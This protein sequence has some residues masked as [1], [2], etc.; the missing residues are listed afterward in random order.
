MIEPF[1]ESI[2][3]YAHNQRRLAL[4]RK[5]VRSRLTD[6]EQSELDSL[7][8]MLDKKLASNDNQLLDTLDKMKQAIANL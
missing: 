1:D 2:S 5:S 7:Q 8:A 6:D 3:W 4:I